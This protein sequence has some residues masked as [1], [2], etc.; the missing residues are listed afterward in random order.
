MLWKKLRLTLDMIKFEHSVFAL[1]FALTGRAAG[2]AGERFRRGAT[3]LE[4]GVDRG[5]DGGGA[6]GRHG[7]QPSGGS[8]YRRAQSAHQDAASARRHADARFRLGLRSHGK[9]ALSVG[10][11]RVESVVLETRAAGAG[12]RVLLFLHQAVYVVFASR[13]RIQ[14]GHRAG[15]GLDR[16][17][18]IARP[19][20]SLAHRGRYLLD[21]RLRR[22]LRVPGLRV[23]FGRGAA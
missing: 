20:H 3:G 2:V 23:R 6:V 18:R 8:K 5:G 12:H 19:P 13:S 11:G 14:F 21:G 15:G 9:R 10:G 22:H 7:L 4:A 16:G 1:P 17:A